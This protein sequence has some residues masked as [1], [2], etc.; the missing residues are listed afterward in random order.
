VVFYSVRGGRHCPSGRVAEISVVTGA[1]ALGC[2]GPM[3]AKAMQAWSIAC[4]CPHPCAQPPAVPGQ[5]LPWAPQG[6]WCT[7]Q[8]PALCRATS[9]ATLWEPQACSW[10]AD[11]MPENGMVTTIAR[12][13]M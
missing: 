12:M 11:A 7:E 3:A 5:L 9:L 1:I 10:A 4:T 8:Q 2:D 13:A 6:W